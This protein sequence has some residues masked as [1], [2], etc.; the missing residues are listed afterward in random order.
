M[1]ATGNTTA[2]AGAGFREGYVEADGFKVRYLEAEVG[3]SLVY[4]HGGRPALR[5]ARLWAASSSGRC[6]QVLEGAGH[7]NTLLHR[8]LVDQSRRRNVP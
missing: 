5:G 2:P 3:R 4:L 6:W 1:T 8:L 7:A